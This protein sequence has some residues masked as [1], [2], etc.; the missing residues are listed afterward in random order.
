MSSP[1]LPLILERIRTGGPMTVAEYVEIALYHEEHGYY[2]SAA[3][4]SGA[5][6]DFFTSVDVGPLFGELLATQFAEMYAILGGSRFDVVEVAAG[7]ARLSA[8]V[9]DEMLRAAPGAYAATRLHLVERA[10]PARAAQRQTLGR[11]ADKVVY[12]GSSLPENV[13]GV[14]FANELLDA[15]PPH[16]VVMR[17]DGL[18]EV[19]V[20]SSGDALVTVED[21]P[22]S[23]LL[24]AYLR[25]VGARLE[26]GWFAEINL[27]AQ[28]WVAAA[29]MALE[30]GFLLLFDYGHDARELYSA[31]HADGTLTFF[32]RHA[33]ETRESGRAWLLRPGECDITSHVD[34]TG[35][36]LA[37]E[38][39]GLLPLGVTDQGY[40]LLS[41][42]LRA[43]WDAGPANVASL[44]RRLAL[45]TLVLPGGIGSTHKVLA[46]AK[47]IG[48]PSLAGLAVTRRLT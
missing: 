31:T 2:A 34:L 28:A 37:A 20:T 46:F 44:E 48:S 14:I 18:R 12:S 43:G 33:A 23:D 27:Q 32:S 40:F 19:Y 25:K 16:L 24:S 38:A 29:A 26:P 8:D 39:S 22:S 10:S 47:R 42:A 15:L 3:R 45:K 36:G 21:R 7:N 13:A 1:L 4:R 9:L 30:R 11:H 6:G 41:L 17:E 35:V 5:R